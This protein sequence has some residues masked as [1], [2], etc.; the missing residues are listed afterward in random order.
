MTPVKSAITP[1]SG[2]RGTSRRVTVS[3][4]R[5]VAARPN[6]INSKGTGG[7]NAGTNLSADTMTMNASAAAATLFSRVCAAPPPLMIQPCGSTWSAPSIAMSRWST[8]STPV[9]DSTRSPK[10]RAACSVR[11]E[12]AT[13]TMSSC[14][15]LRT[16]SRCATVD[17]VP[18][19]TRMPSVTKAAAS[20]AAARFSASAPTGAGCR[21]PLV[22]RDAL[23]A[24]DPRWAIAADR[25][26]EPAARQQRITLT[27]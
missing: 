15:S 19:P 12:V 11:I 3:S 25:R 22:S 14:R 27:P 17:P 7:V 18:K 13:H 24:A 8:P 4:D 2:L 16:S 9:K 6:S 26:C 5:K 21:A 20:S 23:I 1:P 10:A